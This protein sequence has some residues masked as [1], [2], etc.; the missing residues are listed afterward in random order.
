MKS[1]QM[2]AKRC[3][4]VILSAV[5]V[6]ASLSLSGCSLRFL[7]PDKTPSN[8]NNTVVQPG[9]TDQN[10]AGNEKEPQADK[11]TLP[12]YYNPLTG[13]ASAT[14][15]SLIRPVSVSLGG[16]NSPQYGISDA[17]II[18]EAP[19]ENGGVRRMMITT[20]YRNASH[21]GA[22]GSTRSYLLSISSDFGA[23]SV[24]NRANDVRSGISYPDYPCLNYEIDGATT[25][26]FQNEGEGADGHLYTSGTRLIGALENFEKRGVT[27]PYSF[28]EYGKTATPTGR[29]AT[30]VIIPFSSTAVTQFLYN[31]ESKTYLSSHNATP[32]LDSA[33]GKQVAFSNLLLLHCESSIY[34]RA[35][36]T[37]F[38][39]NT[40]AGGA[41]YYVSCG[42]VCEI[43]WSRAEDGKLLLQDKSG[44]PLS[45]NRGS[46]YIGLI[47][48][49]NSSSVLIVE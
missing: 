11:P 5:L 30:G 3:M 8:E 43:T 47:D 39:L 16:G 44:A 4:T 1:S 35:S 2:K 24:C 37:E 48:L 27:L 45:V 19:V 10:N 36:G 26:F 18:I 14:D 9:N 34:N 25:V 22:I 23:V 6:V 33:N 13:L 29:R 28:V 17:G 7:S 21:I 12:S 40:E 15:L 20:A 31:S 42:Y 46:T 41:G 38:E 32:L 49:V